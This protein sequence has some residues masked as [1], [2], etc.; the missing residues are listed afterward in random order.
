MNELLQKHGC[1]NVF[2]VPEGLKELMADISRE[3]LRAQPQDLNDFIA[4]YLSVLLIT[5]E[6][7]VMAV[8][9]L[10]DL[11]DCRPTLLEHLHQLG[12]DGAQ[13]QLLAD[14]IKEEIEG[15]EK[16]EGKETVK[17]YQIIKKILARRQLDEAMTAKVCQVARNAY[18]DYWYRKETLEKGLKVKSNI[19]WEVAAEHTLELYK[20]TK[21]TFTELARATEKIQAAYRGYH[22]RR[23]ILRH[24]QPKTK[25][26]APKAELP[27][28]PMDLGGSREIDLGPIIDIKVRADNVKAMFDQHTNQSLGLAYDPM[29]TITHVPDD[30]EFAEAPVAR[31]RSE[32]RSLMVGDKIGHV[33]T[34][35]PQLPMT[36]TEQIQ[37]RTSRAS[38]D[39]ASRLSRLPSSTEPGQGR[40]PSVAPVEGSNL[41][42]SFA[43]VPPEVIQIISQA[44]SEA[45]PAEIPEDIVQDDLDRS[46]ADVSEPTD[47]VPSSAPSTANT[48][49]VE[50]ETGLNSADED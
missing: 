25:K 8:R 11:C 1:A 18:R 46:D 17:E 24:L 19:P 35:Q 27:G 49:D 4:N 41:K 30:E 21:P 38:I 14:V 31:D 40:L 34:I 28:P 20:K 22:V 32:Q 2:S 33:S 5:R 29:K 36:T 37:S 48:T 45:D 44:T 3:V 9:I 23:N 50:D 39:P 43:N 26:K 6:H 42:I 47:S 15:S 7:G 16:D 10:D 12:L 13:T